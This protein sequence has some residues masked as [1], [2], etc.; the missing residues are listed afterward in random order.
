VAGHR[1]PG[2]P[3]DDH[4]YFEKCCSKVRETS[5]YALDLLYRDGPGDRKR[6]EEALNQVLKNQYM[7]PGARWYGT[8]KRTPEEPDPGPNAVMWQDYDPNWREFNGTIFQ[9]ILIEYPDRISPELAQRLYKSIDMAVEGEK[10]EGRLVPTYTNPSLMYGS[11]WDF[12]A[13]HDKRA[14]WK[15]ESSDWIESVYGLFKKYDAFSEFNSPTYDGVDMFALALWREYGSTEQIRMEGG[16][17]EAGLWKDIGDLFQP[18][19][20]TLSGPYDR[21]YGMENTGDGLAGLMR[22]AKDAKGKPLGIDMG[23]NGSGF[24]CQM[25]ILGV[26]IS[27]DSLGKMQKFEGEHFFKKQISDERTATA[28]IG[29]NVVFGGEATSKTRDVG[30]FSQFHPVT[31]QWRMPS[32][33]IGWVRVAASPMIDAIA[34]EHGISIST[35]GTIRFRIRANG[36]DAAKLTQT[37]WSLPG[38]RVAVSSDSQSPVTV[39]KTDPATLDP[40]MQKD[41]GTDVVYS[42]ITKLRLEIKPEAQ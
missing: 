32:G 11:L 19:I 10:A 7:T 18:E 26:R 37:L 21:S 41:E 24:S 29:K 6:A 27:E 30:H 36:L 33:G 16:A 4:H 3:Q 38:L 12:A 23:A 13:V 8:F 15:K 17:M 5:Y 14:D 9:M 35:T 25:A 31:I 42:G 40:A 2:N 34:D 28:W 22:F 20:R 39:E 1:Y